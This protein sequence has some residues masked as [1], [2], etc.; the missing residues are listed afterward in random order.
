MWQ[1]VHPERAVYIRLHYLLWHICSKQ[2][3]WKEK[4]PLLANCSETTFVSR[5][6]IGKHVYVAMDTHATMEVL[7]EQVFPT[8]SVQSGYNED[9]W[10]N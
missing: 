4:Q 9:N 10:G 5:Q 1:Y 6:R 3:L 7:L 8:R 2:E